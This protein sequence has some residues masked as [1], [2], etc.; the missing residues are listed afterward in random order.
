MCVFSSLF[1]NFIVTEICIIIFLIYFLKNFTIIEV[2]M[3]NVLLSR[4]L[5]LFRTL[6]C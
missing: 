4:A 3:K 6:F 5:I 1:E 2:N